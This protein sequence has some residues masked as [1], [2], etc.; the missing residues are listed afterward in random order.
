MCFQNSA[1]NQWDGTP[2][3]GF[4]NGKPWMRIPDDHTTWNA[5]NQ[6][7]NPSSLWSFWKEMLAIRKTEEDDLVSHFLWRRLTRQVYGKFDLLSP[8][9]E[10]IFAFTRSGRFLT[11]LNFSD[12]KTQYDCPAGFGGEKLVKA[13]QSIGSEVLESKITIPPW[14]GVLYKKA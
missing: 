4:T 6:V 2:N 8:D 10:Q 12:T 11:I 1:D 5:A 9:H 3:A 14:S 13:T 7:K